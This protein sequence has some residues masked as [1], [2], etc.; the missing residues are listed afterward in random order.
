M[1]WLHLSDIHFADYK[2]ST[3]NLRNSLLTKLKEISPDL[4]FIII[5]GDCFF[6]NNSEKNIIPDL[7]KFINKICKTCNIDKSCVYI[8]QGNHDLDRTNEKRNNIID[9][10]R[11]K[12]EINETDLNLLLGIGNDSFRSLYRE[13]KRQEYN[14]FEVFVSNKHNARILSINSCLLSKDNSDYQKLKVCVPNLGDS[15][16]Y[17]EKNDNRLNIGIMHH[18]I[19]W[20]EPSDAKT[21]EHWLEDRGI[22]VLFVGHTHQPNVM[23]LN[24]VS[25]DIY[26]FTSGAL[27]I[28]DYAI[29]SFFMCEENDG[30]LTI[31]LYSYSEKTD[32]WQID[33]H[34]LRKF[35]NNGKRSFALE[36]RMKAPIINEIDY[37]ELSCEE[38]VK[39]LNYSYE[40]KYGSRMFFTD[41]TAEH[42]DFNAWKIVTSLCEIGLPYPV[43]L[44][45]TITVV[46]RITSDEFFSDNLIHSSTIKK[47]IEESI[48]EC[49]KYYPDVSEYDVGLWNSRYSRHYNKNTGFMMV[50]EGNETPISYN[51][52]RTIVLREVI[53][54][55]TDNEVYYRKISSKD[56]EKMSKEIMKFIKSLGISRI[57]KN[58]LY[59][60]ITEYITEP[61]HPWFV[62][63]NREILLHNHKQDADEYLKDLT[64]NENANPSQQIAAA[65]HIFAAYL[66]IYDKYVGCTDIAPIYILKN[67]LAHFSTKNNDTL[68]MRRCML[69]Q[70]KEDLKSHNIDFEY[71][72]SHIGVVYKNIVDRKVVTNAESIDSLNELRSILESISNR[73]DER[74]TNTG[75][76]FN[77]VLKLFH[78]ALGFIVREP[79][80]HFK[81][82]AFVVAPY[83]DDD[84]RRQYN[85]GDDMLVCSLDSCPLEQ[86]SEYLG[87]KRKHIIQ[88]IVLFKR[89]VS[90]FTP[91]ERK[92]I[93]DTLKQHKI[94]VRCI[95]IQ[96]QNFQSVHE[97]GCLCQ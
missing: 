68:P 18:G 11:E 47:I 32:G 36:R 51:L 54:S 41:K 29:P 35:K 75:N 43:A 90:P 49:H 93:R 67:A 39:Q 4:D 59:N 42:E 96:E 28:D 2:F 85:L 58:V 65:Y 53:V 52:L 77:D 50:S 64:K 56:L 88:E 31:T 84:Q 91:E 60:I 7:K 45:I 80:Q 92:T 81:G 87:Q 94:N 25:R 14:D 20:L 95:F 26:Q 48:L 63:N 19:D 62:Y 74:W 61:P 9:Q 22:D 73:L 27:T 66:T 69:V 55:I 40:N 12:A 17:F 1:K 21:F 82:Q 30:I 13:V 38:L 10:I 23:A 97:Y 16:K 37:S 89:D 72:K 46:N 78:N 33:N 70:L 5:T 71:F 8:C 57:Q 34:N 3:Q 24:D 76:G 83:W 6:R 44:R 15:A 86:I 79:L